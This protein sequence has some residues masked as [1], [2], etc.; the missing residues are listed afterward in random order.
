LG[1]RIVIA[2]VIDRV[3]LIAFLA[4]AFA[5]TSLVFVAKL[6]LN[7]KGLASEKILC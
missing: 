5:P 4:A 7:E 3:F 6:E 2:D 1:I